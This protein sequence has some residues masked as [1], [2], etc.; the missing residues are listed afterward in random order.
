MLD[1]D[2]LVSL[3]QLFPAKSPSFGAVLVYQSSEISSSMSIFRLVGGTNGY[4]SASQAH[5]PLTPLPA[6]LFDKSKATTLPK[7]GDP[8]GDDFGDKESRVS[9]FPK[10]STR[11][12][13]Q[14]ELGGATF[15]ELLGR[16]DLREAVVMCPEVAHHGTAMQTSREVQTPR[17]DVTILVLPGGDWGIVGE[18]RLPSH[19]TSYISSDCIILL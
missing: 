1:R 8:V 4:D 9:L 12:E 17:E 19:S 15:A 11:F 18:Y 10:P 14:A 16:G 13:G 7:Q 2:V 3:S 6:K 5:A